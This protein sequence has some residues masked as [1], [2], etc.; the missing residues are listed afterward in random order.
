MIA[1]EHIVFT[2][3][4]DGYIKRV[5]MRSFS[6]NDSVTGLKDQDELIGFSEADTLDTLLAFTES[7]EYVSIPLYTLA[8]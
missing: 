5:S 4:R 8:E 6:S 7:G 1:N 2:L 3:S